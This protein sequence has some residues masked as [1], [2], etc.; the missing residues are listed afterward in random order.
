MSKK[1][2]PAPHHDNP[3]KAFN[4]P[5]LDA[6]WHVLNGGEVGDDGSIIP[7]AK[8]RKATP[9]ERAAERE[10]ERSAQSLTT[11]VLNAAQDAARRSV[12]PPAAAKPARHDKAAAMRA[13]ERALQLA[14]YAEAV[15]PALPVLGRSGRGAKPVD[16]LL[17]RCTE[18]A[19]LAADVEACDQ[20][21]DDWVSKRLWKGLYPPADS[22]HPWHDKYVEARANE[23]LDEPTRVDFAAERLHLRERTG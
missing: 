17:R 1:Q 10:L 18:I 14:H 2:R 23:L 19:L 20:H 9:K 22:R 5:D 3:F 8:T 7:K 16:R 12:K 4:R 6:L 11:D 15:L 21:L 13:A